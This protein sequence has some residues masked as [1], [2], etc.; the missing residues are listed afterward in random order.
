[1]YIPVCPVTAINAHSLAHQ[2]ANFVAGTP[3][4]DFGGG[5]GE[6]EHVDRPTEQSLRG[7]TN[8]VGTQAMGFDKLVARAGAAPGEV[9]A[10]ESANEILGL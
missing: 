6:S 8:E 9:A 10:L 2:R 7:W 3:S 4:P 5:M 1:M